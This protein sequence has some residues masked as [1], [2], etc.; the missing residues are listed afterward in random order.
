MSEKN[1]G[2]GYADVPKGIFVNSICAVS[3]FASWP[4][5]EKSQES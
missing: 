2:A 5:K 3:V 1:P 4:L